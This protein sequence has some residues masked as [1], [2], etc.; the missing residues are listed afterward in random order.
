MQ[1]GNASNLEILST[2]MMSIAFVGTMSGLIWLAYKYHYYRKPRADG[3]RANGTAQLIFAQSALLY[4]ALGLLSGLLLGLSIMGLFTPA[5]VRQENQEASTTASG[6]KAP[7]VGTS[8]SSTANYRRSPTAT[9]S[10]TP[11]RGS[12]TPCC[13]P[14]INLMSPSCAN[15]WT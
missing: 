2:I 4:I 9:I 8:L 11:G 3:T 6:G 12:Q 10:M 1:T 14:A 15:K 13:S 5:P 7:M